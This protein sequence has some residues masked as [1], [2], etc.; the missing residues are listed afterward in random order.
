MEIGWA[1]QMNVT[2]HT[3][4]EQKAAPL[5]FQLKFVYQEAINVRIWNGILFISLHYFITLPFPTLNMKF[6]VK[7]KYETKRLEVRERNEE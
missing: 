3:Q 1:R 6:S 4:S 2:N 5:L 7:I